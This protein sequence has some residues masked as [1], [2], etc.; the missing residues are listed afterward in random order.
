[1]KPC[2]KQQ[3]YCLIVRENGKTYSAFNS[4]DVDGD[5]CPRVK[6]NCPSGTGYELCKS[7]HAEANAAAI[8]AIDKE[9]PG[10]AYLWGHTYACKDC[11]EALTA[12]NVNTIHLMG[13]K[14][15]EDIKQQC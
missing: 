4:C 12:V 8:S 3:T 2:L 1:M 5:I 14:I 10:E 6:A 13:M 11:Q 9:Y 7:T 15:P